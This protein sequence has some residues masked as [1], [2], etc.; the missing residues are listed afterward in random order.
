MKIICLFSE[1]QS[2]FNEFSDVTA[3]NPFGPVQKAPVDKS[4]I[5]L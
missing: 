1:I 5:R 3:K 2:N 4:K